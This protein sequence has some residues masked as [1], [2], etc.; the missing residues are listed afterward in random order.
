MRIR[1][2]SIAAFMFAVANAGNVYAQTPTTSDPATGDPAAADKLKSLEDPTMMKP[3]FSDDA[4]STMRSDEEM[5]AAWAAMSADQQKM[6]KDDCE[7]A[8][9]TKHEEFCGK[10]KSM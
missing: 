4:M 2:L 7:K 1:T 8:A 10:I 5:K 9:N 3:F 6:V